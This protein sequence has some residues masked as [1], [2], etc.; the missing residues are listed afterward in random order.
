MQANSR[1]ARSPQQA[2]FSKVPGS[3]VWILFVVL[4]SAISVLIAAALDSP[5]A[6]VRPPAPQVES[7]ISTAGYDK[8]HRL[9]PFTIYILSQQFSWKLESAVDLEGGRK[10]LDSDLAAAIHRARDVFCIGTASFE[11]ATRTEEARAGQRAKRLAE[12]ILPA[13]ADARQT[14][15]FTLNAG[16]YVGPKG[17]E[18]DQQRKAVIIAT[19]PHDEAVSLSEA[20]KSGLEKEQRTS[21]VIY[22]LLHHYSNSRDWLRVL[23]H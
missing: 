17:L 11:G 7:R 5:R 4:G 3:V 16:Q 1:Y 12:W 9:L 20:L 22:S 21:P 13:I 2:A 15:L 10:L 8:Y 23:Q 14:R 6:E 18:S 19:G